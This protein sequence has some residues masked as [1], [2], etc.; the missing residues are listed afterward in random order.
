MARVVPLAT[1]TGY[2]SGK[3][4]EFR[5]DVEVTVSADYADLLADKGLIEKPK[6]KARGK[7]A[8]TAE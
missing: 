5:A 2:P 3:K 6:A 1:F 8:D 7:A 4:V